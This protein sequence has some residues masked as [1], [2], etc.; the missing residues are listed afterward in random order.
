[1]GLMRLM[2][3][4]GFHGIRTE[5]GGSRS[6]V[7]WLVQ[8]AC[9]HR[10]PRLR[11]LR[12]APAAPCGASRVRSPSRPFSPSRPNDRSPSAASANRVTLP[13]S[14]APASK[15]PPAP[16]ARAPSSSTTG[17][18][19]HAALRGSESIPSIQSI[20]SKR[21][22]T[23]RSERQPCDVARVQSTS[24][25]V[26]AGTRCACAKFLHDGPAAPC[27]ASRFGVHPVHSVHPVQTT[28]HRAKRAPTV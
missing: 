27:S 3:L 11:C 4:M 13:A 12:Q 10:G 2:R 23:E 15:S 17:L 24:V 9:Q 1:M 14:K 6:R 20:L 5:A 28:A 8:L 21:P 26:T 18:Q 25:Q 22:P 19:R 16:V 7:A